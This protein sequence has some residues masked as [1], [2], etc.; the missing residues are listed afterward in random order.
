MARRALAL[1]ILVMSVALLGDVMQVLCFGED[2]HVAFERLGCREHANGAPARAEMRAVTPRDL[3]DAVHVD[4]FLGD[5]SLKSWTTTLA[6][7]AARTSLDA[8]PPPQTPARAGWLVFEPQSLSA[9]RTTVL[10]A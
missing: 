6:A 5:A 3:A 1:L 8:V 4:V 7:I 9:L 2:G 10:R